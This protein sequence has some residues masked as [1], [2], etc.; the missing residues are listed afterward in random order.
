[1]ASQSEVSCESIPAGTG[2]DCL[3]PR[4]QWYVKSYSCPP[5]PEEVA[6]HAPPLE[7]LI[8]HARELHLRTNDLPYLRRQSGSVNL[9]PFLPST[10]GV[11][12]AMVSRTICAEHMQSA[13]TFSQRHSP[14]PYR[15]AIAFDPCLLGSSAR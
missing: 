12:S 2:D 6:G 4:C 9:L 13:S 10:Y 5:P 15:K 1:M 11:N 7:S 3:V 14:A 8:D